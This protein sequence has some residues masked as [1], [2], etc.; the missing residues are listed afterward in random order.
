M[1]GLGDLPDGIFHS[2]AR[3]VS[4]DGEVVVGFGHSA[5]GQEAFRWTQAGGMV[6]LGDLS[7]GG[8]GSF[9]RGI[10]TDGVVIVGQ[11]ESGSGTEA[12]KW[13]GVGGMDGLGDLAGGFFH[14]IAFGVSGDG[15]VIVGESNSTNGAEAF[16][17]TIVDGMQSL[18]D[19]LVNDL[20]LDLTGWT[21]TVANAA[22]DDGTTIVGTGTN[23]DGFNEAWVAVVPIVEA[24]CAGDANGD[25]QVNFADITDVL[26]NWLND[27]TPGTGPGDTNGDGLVNFA[28]ITAV[29]GNWL[30]VCP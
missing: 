11:G 27:Y 18:Q 4:G 23:P 25:G 17:W 10:S 29:L 12:F 5:S 22:S 30:S 19:L 6:G 15:S 13:T 3:G 20:G 7:G 9:A 8:F 26:G 1:V 24:P 2:D 28:D 14:S 16:V 21:L